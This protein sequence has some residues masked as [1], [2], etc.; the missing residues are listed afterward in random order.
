MPCWSG[1]LCSDV[2]RE[3][4]DFTG[5]NLAGSYADTEFRTAGPIGPSPQ[6]VD[7]ADGFGCDLGPSVVCTATD[8]R[9]VSFDRLDL[10][11]ANLSGSYLPDVKL[12]DSILAGI[13]LSGAYLPRFSP[14]GDLNL[15]GAQFGGSYMP[16][17][18]FFTVDLS[19][20][21]F[22]GADLTGTSFLESN[23]AGAS[24]VGADLTFVSFGKVNLTGADLT[25]AD[26]TGAIWTGSTCPDGT[27]ASDSYLTATCAGHL[28]P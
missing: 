10:T 25:G 13:N 24:L 26:L 27:V 22:D 11:A 14:T 15:Q 9:R 18:S 5:A 21:V 4:A 20:A 7:L 6:A 1:P 3:G 28:T 16:G 23:L 12:F 17:S 8:L 19:A 2:R